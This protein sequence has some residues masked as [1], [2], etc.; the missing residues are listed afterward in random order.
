MKIVGLLTIWVFLVGFYFLFAGEMR[1][2]E[3]IAAVPATAVAMSVAA[4]AQ[5]FAER[6][7]ALLGPWGRL[8]ATP[9]IAL[10]SD[11][12]RVCGILIGAIRRPSGAAGV[13]SRQPF[14]TGTCMPKDAGRRGL[15]T[16]AASLAPNGY[17][18]DIPEGE[19]VLVLHRLVAVPPCP[20]RKWPL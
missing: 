20:D 17:V 11:S 7:Y 12:V 5:C 6:R 1:L 19:N 9:C 10:V 16:L 4:L 2:T 8:V 14:D 3:A 15:V 13:F 18:V